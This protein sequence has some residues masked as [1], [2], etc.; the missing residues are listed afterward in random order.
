MKIAEGHLM[1]KQIHMLVSRLPKYS[2]SSFM[3]YLNGKSA[4]IIYDRYANL[5]YKFGNGHFWSE[6]HYVSTVRVNDAT[7]RK[8]IQEQKRYDIM[9]DNLV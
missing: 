7:V 5:K 6:G 1:L 9:Q 2:V 4:F 8:C 3:G